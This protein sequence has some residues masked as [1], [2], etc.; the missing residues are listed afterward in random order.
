MH[1]RTYVRNGFFLG[2]PCSS[3]VSFSINS[4]AH[5]PPPPPPPH[6][7]RR[8]PTP[9]AHIF[10]SRLTSSRLGPS[11]PNMESPSDGSEGFQPRPATIASS[12]EALSERA[13][14]YRQ[15]GLMR[16][17]LHELGFFPHNRVG[18]RSGPGV[19][20]IVQ[21]PLHTVMETI[22]RR[23]PS[24]RGLTILGATILQYLWYWTCPECQQRGKHLDECGWQ[25]ATGTSWIGFLQLSKAL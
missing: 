12:C 19:S 11:M 24:A 14:T 2:I 23:V 25:H 4:L 1:V 22:A 13:Q 21:P 20:W 15:P 5:R 9:H 3:C 7:P 10:R 18:V 8:P 17:P 16:I 6:P